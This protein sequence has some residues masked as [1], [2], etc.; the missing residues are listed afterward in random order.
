[1]KRMLAIDE[2]TIFKIRPIGFIMPIGVPVKAKIAIY[3]EAPPWPTEEYKT[4]PINN[5]KAV[6]ELAIKYSIVKFPF[7]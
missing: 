1:M 3:A 7:K 4:E 6:K 5:K 2:T